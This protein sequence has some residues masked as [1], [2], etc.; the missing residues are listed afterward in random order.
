MLDLNSLNNNQKEA[1]LSNHGPVLVIAGAGSGKTKVLTY[2][3]AYLIKTGQFKPNN[4]LAVTFTNKAA[5]EMKSRV[6]GLLSNEINL[7]N[8]WIGTFH[9]ICVKILKK[10]GR[11]IG[12]D[13]KFTIVD[14]YD[15]KQIIIEAMSQL[16][17]SS[18]AFNPSTILSYISFAKNHL[19]L[20]NA[21]SSTVKGYFHEIVAKIYEQYQKLL[22][23]NNS[24]DFDDLL[25]QVCVLIQ[26]DLTVLDKLQKQFK[27][28]LVD[29]YQDTN[30]AQYMI[31]KTIAKKHQNIFVV[32]DD[33]QSIYSFR[34]A[35]INNIL[36]FEKDFPDAKVITLDQNYRSTQNILNVAYSIICNNTKRK[37]KKLW[38]S[39]LRGNLVDLYVAIDEYDELHWIVNNIKLLRSNSSFEEIAVLYRT[40]AFSRLIEEQL[41]KNGIPY[42]I[43]GN[44]GFYERKE[45]KDI[46]CYV[47]SIYNIKDDISFSRIANTPKRGIGE[48]SLDNLKSYSSKA[49]TGMLE[50]LITNELEL[51]G[52]SAFNK[53]RQLFIE[54]LNKL[55][56]LNPAAIIQYILNETK[57]IEY[58]QSNDT[59]NNNVE[60]K[61]QNI[62]ELINLASKYNHLYGMEGIESFLNEVILMENVP[63]TYNYSN[64]S[65]VSENRVILMT[66]HSAKGLEFDNV[67]IPGLEENIFPHAN[68][69]FSDEEIEEE[70]RLMY[71]AVTRA[72]KRLYLSYAQKRRMYGY[73]QNNLPSRFVK[74]INSGLLNIINS[75][76]I[77]EDDV[78]RSLNYNLNDTNVRSNMC[79][80]ESKKDV[81]TILS[82]GDKVRHPYFG[83]GVVLS[84]NSDTIIVQF[85]LYGEKELLKD[86]PSIVKEIRD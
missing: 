41:V 79:S 26:N 66:I 19:I 69:M 78:E 49:N 2:R 39:N 77:L 53:V 70:R 65:T 14:T 60:D 71:V 44:I 57:Y 27:Y 47:K 76:L 67:F 32:G 9:S 4:I 20:P 31:V 59:T 13:S 52:L 18:K 63:R 29:E 61:V 15:Q 83:K 23:Q 40:N 54:V 24:L 25:M 16:N 7:D 43:F 3:I 30:Y 55:D 84:I 72:K 81:S 33:D 22:K 36:S 38:T 85:D 75:N 28:I 37:D 50:F 86:H 34:G 56:L 80:Q 11:A 35:D 64:S 17:I 6:A 74:E 45:V 62:L 82:I 42:K 48:K 68:A 12:I 1:V 51:Y 46:I 5:D 73:L 10:Y 58:L 8:L 21:Y